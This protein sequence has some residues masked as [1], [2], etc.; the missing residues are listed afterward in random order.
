M[1]GYRLAIRPKT[2]HHRLCFLQPFQL[3]SKG[4]LP[5]QQATRGQFPAPEFAL[6]LNS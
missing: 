5:V 2:Q 6:P 4:R 3:F 1:I